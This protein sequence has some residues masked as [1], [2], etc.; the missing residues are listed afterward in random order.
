MAQE[1]PKPFRFNT[2][3]RRYKVATVSYAAGQQLPSIR[4][5]KTGFLNRIFLVL[6]GVMTLSS[7]GALQDLGPWNLLNRIQLNTNIGA[8]K[9]YDASGYGA[10]LV[11]ATLE[12]G[13]RPDRGGVGDT[14]PHPAVYS[15][16]VASGANNWTM[17]YILPIACNAGMNFDMGLINLQSL[18][19][20]VNLD[21]F[22]GN[23]LDAATNATGF[24]GSIEVWIEYYEVPLPG[25]N[26]L[27]PPLALHRIQ[28]ET[29]PIANTGEQTYTVPKMGK[30][31]QMI[32]LIRCNGTRSDA[33]DQLSVR[34][35]RTDEPYR[36]SKEYLRVLNRLQLGSDLP[37]G[38]YMLDLWHSSEDVGEGDLRDAIDSERIATLE[39]NIT[40]TSGTTL[41][42]GNNSNTIIRRLIQVLE[43]TQRV[44]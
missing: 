40:I 27:L 44:A 14:T 12:R 19:T 7:A 30:L 36:I 16:P 21:I 29:F 13:F 4:M 22:C 35:Q 38:A 9:T 17:N 11:A 1:Q 24:V 43:P 25:S 26:V 33:I 3:Q 8:A 34:F 23:P 5:P 18:Q 2:R 31:L 37:V 20:E 28:E 42:A 15:V 6:K 41:G 32:H 39:S 10:Y